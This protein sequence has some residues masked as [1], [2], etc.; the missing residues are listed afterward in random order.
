VSWTLLIRPYGD[1]AGES[2]GLKLSLAPFRSALVAQ[3]RTLIDGI[4]EYDA[5]I[6]KA[7]KSG[8][9]A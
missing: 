2:Q 9:V 5:A 7:F 1:R 6:A 3:L 4:A 8:V